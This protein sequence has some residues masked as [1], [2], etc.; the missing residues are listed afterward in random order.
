MHEG[1]FSNTK[2]KNINYIDNYTLII[3]YFKISNFNFFYILIFIKNMFSILK[4]I[5]SLNDAHVI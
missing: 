2:F 5:T 3:G 4:L 1:Q